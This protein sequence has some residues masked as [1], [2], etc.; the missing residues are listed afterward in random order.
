MV[1]PR[2]FGRAFAMQN[3][4]GASQKAEHK[5]DRCG[6]ETEISDLWYVSPLTLRSARIAVIQLMSTYDIVTKSLSVDESW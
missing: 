4:L 6:E 3:G 5:V 1:A 2:N